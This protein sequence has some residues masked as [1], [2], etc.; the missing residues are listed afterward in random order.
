MQIY[1]FFS[2]FYI[3]ENSKHVQDGEQENESSL[4]K[5]ILPLVLICAPFFYFKERWCILKKILDVV[6]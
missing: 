3:M 4:I 2:T 5:N 6:C 1:V